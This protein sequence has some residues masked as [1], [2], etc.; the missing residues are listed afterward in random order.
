[1]VT[2]QLEQ[3]TDIPASQLPAAGNNVPVKYRLT[4]LMQNGTQYMAIIVSVN[5]APYGGRLSVKNYFFF[6]MF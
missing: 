5:G 2:Q 4:D 3:V 6:L 1:M